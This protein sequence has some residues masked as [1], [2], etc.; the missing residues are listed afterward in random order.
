MERDRKEKDLLRD[1]E[2]ANAGR[3]NAPDKHVYALKTGGA[4]AA[5]CA[6]AAARDKVAAEAAEQHKVTKYG[7]V[8][9]QVET[10]PDRWEWGQ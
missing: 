10:E 2:M 4:K 8:R 5:A 6:V 1:E 3:F 7:G 9:C